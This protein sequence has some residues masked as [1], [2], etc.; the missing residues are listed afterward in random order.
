MALTGQKTVLYLYSAFRNFHITSCFSTQAS[1]QNRLLPISLKAITEFSNIEDRISG[2]TSLSVGPSCFLMNN[3]VNQCF[4]QV[5]HKVLLHPRECLFLML[6]L[7][8]IFVICLNAA[9]NHG[10]SKTA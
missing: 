1:P 6:L 10:I 8:L 7:I 4:V 5:Q 3:S 2:R 9:K